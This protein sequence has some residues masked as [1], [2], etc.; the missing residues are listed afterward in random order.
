MHGDIRADCQ[1]ELPGACLAESGVP[2]CCMFLS[3]GASFWDAQPQLSEQKN[4]LPVTGSARTVTG[5]SGLLG[6]HKHDSLKQTAA[7]SVPQNLPRTAV[8]CPYLFRSYRLLCLATS[9]YFCDTSV[10]R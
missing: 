8:S 5:S 1:D 9:V 4:N 7:V 10:C 2:A 3:A 6:W